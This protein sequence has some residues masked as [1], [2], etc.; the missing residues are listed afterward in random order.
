M[1]GDRFNSTSLGRVA[2]VTGAAGGVAAGINAQLSG[3]GFTLICADLGSRG[4]IAAE[5]VKAQGG[6]A[7]PVSLD[8]TSDESVHAAFERLSAESLTVDVLVN[9]AGIMNRSGLLELTS[10]ELSHVLD[11]NLVGPFRMIQTFAPRMV[12]RSWGRIVNISSIAAVNGYPFPSYAASKAGLSNLTRS[13][14]SDLWG[15]G[16][17]IN[18]VCPGPVDAPMLSAAVREELR[19]SVPIER[20][21]LPS[22]IG[23]AVSYLASDA[24]AGITG[25][26]LVVDGGASAYFQ[27]SRRSV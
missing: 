17:T 9:A 21:V 27:L 16:V 12:Q 25:A 3:M 11:V 20:A 4:E 18:N 6:A 10:T 14:L 1:Q 13:L 22:E 15:T 26:D 7:F 2:L 24:A 23:S 19:T 8:V 5:K